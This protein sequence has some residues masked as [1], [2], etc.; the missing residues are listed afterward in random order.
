M[1]D[2]KEI[3]EAINQLENLRC[4][5]AVMSNN[6]G[7]SEEFKKDIKALELAIEYLKKEFYSEKA[8][9]ITIRSEYEAYVNCNYSN[10]D[11]ETIKGIIATNIGKKLLE[12]NLIDF[13]KITKGK[14]TIG[15][16]YTFRGEINVA[17]S[18]TSL[19]YIQL[20]KAIAEG[21]N[22]G[23]KE[24]FNEAEKNKEVK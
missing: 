22:K 1:G 23:F 2:K 17:K 14:T 12:D 9:I 7:E 10:T 24:G 5:C 4:H 16:I 13:Y 11:I 18:N 21:F 20:G 6:S 3:K 19:E 8:D 15:D